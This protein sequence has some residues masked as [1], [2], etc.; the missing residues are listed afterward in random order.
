MAA[1]LLVFCT[2]CSVLREVA[3]DNEVVFVENDPNEIV[4]KLNYFRSNPEERR[5]LS[6]NAIALSERYTY[7][8]RAE[9][10]R[11]FIFAQ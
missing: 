6:L 1:G 4:N 11:D 10:I 3:T 8:R 7:E 9:S 2:D 5:R